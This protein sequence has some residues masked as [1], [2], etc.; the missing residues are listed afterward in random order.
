MFALLVLAMITSGVF[1]GYWL[2]LTGSAVGWLHPQRQAVWMATAVTTILVLATVITRLT[3]VWLSFRHR[4]EPV[5][6]ADFAREMITF[7]EAAR[8]AGLST[9]PELVWNPI[10]CDA[11]ARAWGRR[12]H[13]RVT[14]SPSLLGMARTRPET[15][16]VVIQHELAHIRL[17]DVWLSYSTFAVYWATLAALLT[18]I[19]TRVVDHD[20]S[21]LPTYLPRAV[22]L[23]A[24]VHL[25]GVATLRRREHT[26]DLVAAAALS[27]P[28]AVA[29]VL[30]SST[31]GQRVPNRLRRVL[32]LHPSTAWRAH[33]VTDPR[34]YRRLNAA[35]FLGVGVICGL[36]ISLMADLLTSLGTVT[37]V[38]IARG[39]A[40]GVAGAYLAAV[41]QRVGPYQPRR[42]VALPSLSF[43]IGV[44]SAQAISLG[45]AHLTTLVA[46]DVAG[47]AVT[48]V[49]LASVIVWASDITRTRPRARISITI[50]VALSFVLAADA[51][52]A[53]TELLRVGGEESLTGHLTTVLT[54]RPAATAFAV[55]ILIVSLPSVLRPS[56]DATWLPARTTLA[57]VA[58]GV[59]A[60]VLI[61]FARLITSPDGDTAKL[62][63]Y[64]RSLWTIA[65]AAVLTAGIGVVLHP[66]EVGLP[67]A[68]VASACVVIT[69]AVAFVVLNDLCFHS[70][71]GV[72]E[73]AG[74][75]RYSGALS[76]LL[77]LP[78]LATVT[79]AAEARTSR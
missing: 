26:A 54:E 17:Y 52:L 53:V 57:S 20:L 12:G 14:V 74:I 49:L 16:T 72:P 19:A 37:A 50:A 6:T 30:G 35:E 60:G 77:V 64:D 69:G 31:P 48:A 45:G 39:T 11:E 65:L 42:A 32:T 25:V 23:A 29:R 41:L 33:V 40:F 62:A 1:V 7:A 79:V 13:Y 47:Y 51:V 75:V 8:K 46:A 73:A 66:A 18:P 44:A 10:S 68:A 70:T 5:P 71:L 59:G 76:A 56:H 2:S 55:L 4:W 38:Q 27:D 61:L 9:V 15:F 34:S 24:V 22:A 67:H 43:A 28:E 36:P 58:G 21:V 78:L 63:F 3:P